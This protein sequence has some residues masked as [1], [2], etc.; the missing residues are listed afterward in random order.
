V[1]TPVKDAFCGETF[2]VRIDGHN[3]VTS[4]EHGCASKWDGRPDYHS[5]YA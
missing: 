1:V 2:K 5:W 3:Y 4:L